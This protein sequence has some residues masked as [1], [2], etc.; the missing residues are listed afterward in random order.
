MASGLSAPLASSVRMS[1]TSSRGFNS[2]MGRLHGGLFCGTKGRVTGRM[3]CWLLL[4]LNASI[5]APITPPDSECVLSSPISKTVFVASNPQSQCGRS[6]SSK[7]DSPKKIPR[8]ECSFV[9][10]LAHSRICCPMCKTPSIR[11]GTPTVQRHAHMSFCIALRVRH[12]PQI[13]QERA[14]NFL[15]LSYCLQSI[16][17]IIKIDV[18]QKKM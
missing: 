4:K 14:R 10:S 11:S 9:P 5:K 18:L 7:R 1:Y 6:G 12:H 13:I 15:V 16:A 2:L 8:P 17:H 3:N